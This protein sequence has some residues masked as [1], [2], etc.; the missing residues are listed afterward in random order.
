MHPLQ[1]IIWRAWPIVTAVL[2]AII[3]AILRSQRNP[4]IPLERAK[5]QIQ[6]LALGVVAGLLLLF[7][8]LLV[9]ELYPFGL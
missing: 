7:F 8:S 9:S 3:A 2:V 6:S 4:T 5:L 1:D